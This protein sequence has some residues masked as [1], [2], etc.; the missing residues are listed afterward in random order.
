VGIIPNSERL[1]RKWVD[2]SGAEKNFKKIFF[3]FE[4]DFLKKGFFVQALSSDLKRISCSA[5]SSRPKE[6]NR[7][8][9]RFSA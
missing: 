1:T 6:C 7:S 5:R 4:L 9:R 8:V 3:D 2:F